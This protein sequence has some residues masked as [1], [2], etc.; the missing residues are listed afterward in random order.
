MADD[1]QPQT[2]GDEGGGPDT[3]DRL[4]RLEDKVDR[5]ADA[6]AGIVPATRGQAEQR[7]EHRLDR[8]SSVEEQ[9]RAELARKDKAAAEKAEQDRLAAELAG[10]RDSV[11]A[12]TEKRPAAPV[13]LREKIL[14]WSR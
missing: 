2:T 9:V 14:G 5:L 12:L 6:V 10:V 8:P 7:T 4:G 11:A 3:G 13:P 1:E